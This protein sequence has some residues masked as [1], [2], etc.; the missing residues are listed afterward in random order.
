MITY[1]MDVNPYQELFI[2]QDLALGTSI[3]NILHGRASF[4]S[5][6]IDR[7]QS[8]VVVVLNNSYWPFLKLD[9][10]FKCWEL[11]DC[12][13]GT[14][15]SHPPEILEVSLKKPWRCFIHELDGQTTL[16]VAIHHA[17]ADGH[18]FQLFWTDLT[19]HLAGNP[20][21]MP[22]MPSL[23]KLKAIPAPDLGVIKVIED[24]GLGSVERI[25]LSIP[26][27]RKEQ[28][29]HAAKGTGITLSTALLG[30]L[31]QVLNR[32][33]SHLEIPLQLGM[34]LRNRGS[35]QAKADFSSQVNF[36]PLAHAKPGE[37]ND[38]ERR[39]RHLFRH[40]SFPLLE[41]M[42]QHERNGAFNVLFSYQKESYQI[43]SEFPTSQVQFLP[44]AADET[45]L[46]V[47]ILEFGQE[48][49]QISFD[50]RT[51]L[52]DV[53]FWR[54][55]IVHFLQTLREFPLRP[56]SCLEAAQLRGEVH[57]YPF[58][59]RFDNAAD[60][61][62]ALII[63]GT[64]ITYGALREQLKAQASEEQ[65][66][67]S[68]N[69]DRSVKSII[70][71][72]SAWKMNLPVSFTSSQLTKCPQ[73]DWLYL[74]ET[75]GSTGTPKPLLIEKSGIESLLPAWE[76]RLG[77]S[78]ESVHLCLAD[79]R[80]DVFFGDVFRSLMLGGTLVLATESERLAPEQILRLIQSH[81]VTH[82]ESTPSFLNLV[83]PSLRTAPTLQCLICGS[84]AMSPKLHKNLIDLGAS[85]VRIVNSYG[86]TEVSIDS[87]L[88]NLCEHA[89]TYPL[90]FPLG[91]QHFTVINS[92]GESVPFG[93]WGELEITGPCVA[94]SLR[95][96]PRFQVDSSGQRR[97]RT[98]DRA[99]V[100]PKFGLIVR[101]RMRDDFIKVNG[102]RIPAKAIEQ[103]VE[104]NPRVHRALLIAKGG[105]A[106][107]LHDS[108]LNEEA[109]Q[110]W[111][112]P[113]FARHHL[114]DVI[115]SHHHWP[116]NQNGKMDHEGVLESVKLDTF[117]SEP[118]EASDSEIEL[119]LQKL[120][121]EFGKP[122]HGGNDLLI[123][124]GWNSID[125]L[126]FC[127]LWNINGY[128]LSPRKWLE[129]PTLNHLLEHSVPASTQP[130][131]P[132]SPAND[133]ED[134]DW[135]EFLDALNQ[136]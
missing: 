83:L 62:A 11:A 25:T 20:L 106:I 44:T 123:F 67:V 89:G 82:L 111:L 23:H 24:V 39:V 18:S 132:K 61:K 12:W 101:G 46:G 79:Q 30:C 88:T 41:W 17:W 124:A 115:L 121:I 3:N 37:W 81:G 68:L 73:G 57:G 75:S 127:N 72:L 49:L 94:H 36:L 120:L 10:Q 103:F 43:D 8:A 133:V 53:C 80:F 59:S 112:R 78:K 52:A 58:W 130:L 76:S 90:G 99:M 60:N 65:P 96:N 70:R 34:A 47:H 4:P 136:A 86:L 31:Q 95:E 122:Y 85:G 33:E 110:Q 27:R 108:E 104:S 63:D 98:G 74:A 102:R 71:M 22:S 117:A 56:S 100:H 135:G 134:G 129:R 91:N 66:Y 28:L 93:V 7:L 87:A 126:S 1:A 84:E 5:I 42:R 48:H 128:I 119:A 107:L 15:A 14:L 114:P 21:S 35:R 55:V 40:Q 116:V 45:V 131:E 97:Y 13:Q 19:A 69:P 92:Q 9:E 29:E 113:V 32:C 26:S 64:R 109:L 6:G 2:Q 54:A 38:V 50:V 125:F 118:W 105:V 77:I 16:D 51:D